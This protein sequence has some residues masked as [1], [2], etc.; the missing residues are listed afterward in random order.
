MPWVTVCVP[1]DALRT[2]TLLFLTLVCLCAGISADA[3]KPGEPVDAKARGTYARAIAWLKKGDK[4]IALDEFRK[5][6]KQDGGHCAECLRQALTIANSIEAY[7]DAADIA[8]ESLQIA[9]TDAEKAAL[10]YRIGVSLQQQG[11]LSKK[12]KWFSESCDEFKTALD[13]MPS[14]PAVHYSWGV[15]LAYLHQDD[16]AQKEFSVFLDQ[17][18]DNPAAHE[19]AQRYLKR[20]ELARARMAPP[21]AITTLDGQHITMDGLTGKVVLVDFWAMWCGPCR[22]ALPQM[23]QIVKKFEGQPLVVLSISLDKD[24]D[25]WK[26]FVKANGMTWLQYRDG[27]F[28][29]EVAKLFNVN[30]IPATFSI[31]ADGVLED[32]HVGDAE[33]EGKLKKMIAQANE[34]NN[35]KPLPA[36]TPGVIDGNQ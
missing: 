4:A 8:R 25:K 11:I 26:D 35:R 31:D 12:D 36:V 13:L 16:A 19:R 30:A 3:P 22:N 14:F 34:V 27:G 17:D 1:A 18:R 29:G 28:N 10:H 33:I 21:F 7:K 23:R 2:A 32:Q 6:N 15:S 5:A 20:V 9:G 24:A